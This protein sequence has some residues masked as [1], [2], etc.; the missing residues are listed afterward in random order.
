MQLCIQTSTII[1]EF[2]FERGYAMLREA[3]FT[4]IDWNLDNSLSSKELKSSALENLCIFERPLEECLAHYAEELTHIRANNLTISQAHAPF[5]SCFVDRPETLDYMIGIYRRIIEFC[6]AVGCGRVIIHG[7]SL[8]GFD[9]VNTPESIRAINM[10]LYESLIDVLVNTD[11]TVCLENLFS[12]SPKGTIEGVC[13]DAHEAVDY[14]DTLN[15]KAG[16]PCFG[17]CLDTGH[18]NLLRHTFRTYVPI[19]GHRI[20]ALHI[21]DNNGQADQHMMPFTGTVNWEEFCTSLHAVGYTGDLS[22]ETFCQTRRKNIPADLAPLF[23]HTIAEIGVY[24]R[25]R[26]CG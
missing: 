13:S 4:A 2:G 7:T 1:Q 9:T 20:C 26:I 21:H 22:F 14:I 6:D 23:L 5:P 15:A 11:V 12:S 10:K 24:F 17:L 8:S 25:S 19:L 16:K 18:L 3:G